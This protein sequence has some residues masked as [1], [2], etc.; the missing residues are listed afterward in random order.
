MN[1]QKRT[2]TFPSRGIDE[3]PWYPSVISHQSRTTAERDPN[4]AVP[5]SLHPA[6]KLAALYSPGSTPDMACILDMMVL[7]AEDFCWHRKAVQ[8]F[9]RNTRLA[10]AVGSI[11]QLE[12][13]HMTSAAEVVKVSSMVVEHRSQSQ[14]QNCYSGEERPSGQALQV[15]WMVHVEARWVG[16]CLKG[17]V[18]RSTGVLDSVVSRNRRSIAF[19][20]VV[21]IDVSRKC[22]LNFGVGV[23]PCHIPL[24]RHQ[25]HHSHID[26]EMMG[27][28]HSPGHPAEMVV[29]SL[30]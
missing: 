11:S 1:I 4:S 10:E 28:I 5:F 16:S 8:C 6:L 23:A 22:H 14:I 20:A 2:E 26:P 12:K 25:F 7:E 27:D 24:L 29:R 30:D 13:S 21:G 18:D 15:L 17:R 9:L 3:Q 19:E